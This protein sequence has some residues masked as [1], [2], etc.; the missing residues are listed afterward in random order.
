MRTKE[1]KEE[2]IVA[3]EGGEAHRVLAK[4]PNQIPKF[5]KVARV[6]NPQIESPTMR[7]KPCVAKSL[8]FEISWRRHYCHTRE[9]RHAC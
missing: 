2:S 4:A 8:E 6:R 1:G 5:R 9:R 7:M 3:E